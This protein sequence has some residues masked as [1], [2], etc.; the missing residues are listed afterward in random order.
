VSVVLAAAPAQAGSHS[1]RINEVFSTADGSVQFIELWEA[2]GEPAETFMINKN[3]TSVATGHVFLFPANFI[4]PTDDKHVLLATQSFANLPGAP[5]PDYI[6]QPGFFDPKGDTLEYFIYDEWTF[7][8][9]PTD[10]VNSLHRNFWTTTATGLNSPTNYQGGTGEVD[11]CPAD[12]NDD[13]IVNGFDLALLLGQWGPCP[14]RGECAADLDGN[15]I[16]N[17]FDL[18]MLLAV[19][20]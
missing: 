3:I 11:A 18:A 6:I 10:C 2:F 16:V 12:L 8:A 14:A 5:T 20:G 4:P 19:W 15:D 7:G 17:G 1:W 13:G 9:I